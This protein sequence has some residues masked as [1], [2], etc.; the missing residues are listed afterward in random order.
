MSTEFDVESFRH[1]FDEQLA[2]LPALQARAFTLRE[3][4]GWA[5]A[6]ICARL[7]ISEDRLAELLLEARLAMCRALAVT[8]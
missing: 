1:A 6:M 8:A 4:E 5:P 3:L 2:Q 7:A